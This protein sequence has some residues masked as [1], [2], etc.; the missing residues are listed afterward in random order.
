M[1]TWIYLAQHLSVGIL[2]AVRQLFNEI[3][4]RFTMPKALHKLKT[5]KWRDKAMKTGIDKE[6]KRI[7]TFTKSSIKIKFN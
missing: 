2:T 3:N 1:D 6:N 7:Y 4:I 5:N